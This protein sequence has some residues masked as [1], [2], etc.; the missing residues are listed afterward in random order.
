M[1]D[2]IKAALGSLRFWYLVVAF[3]A[4]LLGEYGIISD[5]IKVAIEG[6]CGVSIG[7]VSL[8]KFKKQ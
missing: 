3:I 2:K 7:V 8:D 1:K 4:Y 5:T 6:F